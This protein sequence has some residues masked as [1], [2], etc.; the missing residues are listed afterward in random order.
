MAATDEAPASYK[1]WYHVGATRCRPRGPKAR[2]G[3]APRPP[4]AGGSRAAQYREA[5]GGTLRAATLSGA[6]PKTGSQAFLCD[7]AAA[8]VLHFHCADDRP[9]PMHA[10]PCRVPS[11][12]APSQDGPA[13]RGC[14]PACLPYC[15]KAEYSVRCE[16]LSPL[17]VPSGHRDGGQKKATRRGARRLP[18]AR[19][20]S[21]VHA[22]CGRFAS[23]PGAVR[24][25]WPI[26][27]RDGKCFE[28]PRLP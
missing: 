14:A 26:R 18:V 17:V 5:Q 7:P 1:P 28:T 12:C 27:A 10:F 3:V 11:G 9:D 4:A 16:H 8:L 23:W 25:G 22:T 6:A 15:L 19:R 21:T 13:G 24:A 20:P 2:P